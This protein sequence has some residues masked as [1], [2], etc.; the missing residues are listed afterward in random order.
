MYIGKSGVLGAGLGEREKRGT[1]NLAN[2]GNWRPE[3]RIFIRGPGFRAS[4][5]LGVCQLGLSSRRRRQPTRRSSKQA[6]SGTSRSERLVRRRKGSKPRLLERLLEAD[7]Q[8][9]P[10]GYR[11]ARPIDTTH[12]SG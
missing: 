6:M 7:T 8:R 9:K 4:N 10:A 5:K 2:K 12:L 3:G 1:A 11:I